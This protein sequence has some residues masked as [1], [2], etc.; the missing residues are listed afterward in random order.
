MRQHRRPGCR[1]ARP[2]HRR[3]RGQPSLQG[4]AEPVFAGPDCFVPGRSRHTRFDCD[5][6]SDV[7]SS[8]LS[9]FLCEAFCAAPAAFP[10]Y[11]TPPV[12]ACR[13][14]I[15]AANYIYIDA[16]RA[17]S[18]TRET[19][20]RYMGKSSIVNVLIGGKLWETGTGLRRQ[21]PTV[22]SVPASL[23]VIHASRGPWD[24]LL[25][26]AGLRPAPAQLACGKGLPGSFAPLPKSLL[27][28]LRRGFRKARG[29]R[30]PR[31]SR[32]S[33]TVESVRR[34]SS[35]QLT[36]RRFSPCQGHGRAG[37]SAVAERVRAEL[38]PLRQAFLSIASRPV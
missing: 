19:L 32:Q 1:G 15:P 29:D 35:L 11:R 7:C 3:P 30:G 2:S 16:V 24:W 37:R 38:P 27:A 10:L 6:S 9:K 25:C 5:W 12:I 8:D 31:A 33:R 18:V 36:P 28:P 20:L 14:P 17:S 23:S 13:W 22:A 26:R 34:R 21:Q 4:R